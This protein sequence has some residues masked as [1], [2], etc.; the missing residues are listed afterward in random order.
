[1]KSVF[2]FI[3]RALFSMIFIIS[4][5]T[6]IFTWNDTVQGFVM[7][8]CNWHMHLDGTNY[9][10]DFVQFGMSS[11]PL[12]VGIAMLLEIAGGLMILFNFKM[13]FGAFILL[14]FLI[15][16]TFTYHAFWFEVGME[17]HIQVAMF[18]K[19]LSMMGALLYFVV[20]NNKKSLNPLPFPKK[21]AK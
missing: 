7:T 13:R 15:P 3:A 6:K 5:V 1:M 11:A 2:L 21:V 18:M 19:N 9:S 8:L 4:G 12:I 14:I 16:V 17:Y 20:G 10:N